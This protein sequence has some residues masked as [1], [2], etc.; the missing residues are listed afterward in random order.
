LS[1][2]G[3]SSA[4]G[5]FGSEELQLLAAGKVT[6][7]QA[8]QPYFV[9]VRIAAAE[10]LSAQANAERLALLHEALAIQPSGF[11]ETTNA[12]PMRFT[13]N[14][15]ALRVFRDEAALGH[16][17]T[18]LVAVE[19]LLHATNG[20]APETSYSGNEDEV[21]GESNAAEDASETGEN[22]QQPA[23]VSD[24]DS[25]LADL[26]RL[27][28]LPALYPPSEAERVKLAS[29]I[30]RVFEDTD[31]PSSALPYWKL[32]RYLQKDTPQWNELNRHVDKI[33]KNLWLEKQNASRRPLIQKDLNQSGIVRP[34]LT[35]ADATHMEA[36]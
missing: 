28:P 23:W 17:A 10:D 12:T 16:N 35:L 5:K 1:L 36:Q 11:E 22:E 6:G 18:A 8:R 13:R 24:S 34:R 9:A 15:L 27:A 29:L 30:A 20:Y 7:L 14:D 2:H 3:K 4:T 31:T 19:P 25:T 32:V 21:E 26:E 33:E